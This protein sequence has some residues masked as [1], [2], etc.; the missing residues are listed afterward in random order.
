MAH[1]HL[2]VLA[3]RHVAVA[4]VDHAY[5]NAPHGSAEGAR[6]DLTRLEV[7]P[8]YTHHLCHAPDLDQRKAKAPFERQV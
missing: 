2:P 3:V 6:A 5:F 1:Q 7:V 4:I 8:Q